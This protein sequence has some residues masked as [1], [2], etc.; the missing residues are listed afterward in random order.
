[1]A[2]TRKQQ[3]KQAAQRIMVQPDSARKHVQETI[4]NASL[5]E[6]VRPVLTKNLSPEQAAAVMKHFQE[7]YSRLLLPLSWP[8]VSAEVFSDDLYGQA[9]PALAYARKMAPDQTIKKN[10]LKPLYDLADFLDRQAIQENERSL[11]LFMPHGFHITAEG[12]IQ[13][14]APFLELLANDPV[15]G[16]VSGFQRTEGHAWLHP[17]LNGATRPSEANPSA[18]VRYGWAIFLASA[19]LNLK[20]AGRREFMESLGKN[21]RDNPNLPPDSPGIIREA[22]NMRV[23]HTPQSGCKGLLDALLDAFS[24]NP[25]HLNPSRG[26]GLRHE[27]SRYSLPGRY[28]NNPSNEDR[29]GE[30][31]VKNACVIFVADGVSTADLGTGEEAAELAA[32]VV[33]ERRFTFAEWVDKVNADN[34]DQWLSQAHGSLSQIYAAVDDAIAG[35]LNRLSKESGLRNPAVHPMCTT[36]SV[37]I[38]VDDQA[39][40]HTLGDSPALL[41]QQATGRLLK[42]SIDHNVRGER[43]EASSITMG[44]SGTDEM[45]TRV[46]GA[47]LSPDNEYLPRNDGAFELQVQLKNSDILFLASDGLL[48]C[49]DPHDEEHALKELEKIV[50]SAQKENKSLREMIQAMV[51]LADREKSND[52]IT[53]NGV[54]M[55][56]QNNTGKDT[57]NG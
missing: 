36:L 13:V 9:M 49:I 43:E 35:E 41:Y 4:S 33:R 21:R 56:E 29:A 16:K 54:R 39:V 53:V 3:S 26:Q 27:Q 7:G 24:S 6:L 38:V 44:D 25:L 1:M 31:A 55:I 57:E 15:T 17:D 50:S 46:A 30:I 47:N 18:R 34:N 40:V 42:L 20:P 12:R 37:A 22:L 51:Y 11:I 8:G 10:V 32:R 19:W 28:K 23:S 52:N 2:D 14:A 45:L 48:K 5:Q